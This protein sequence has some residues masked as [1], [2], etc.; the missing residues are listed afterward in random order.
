VIATGA[1]HAPLGIPD[2]VCLTTGTGVLK[3]DE[4]PRRGVFV[5]GGYIAFE[6]TLVA[7]RTSAQVHTLHRGARPLERFDADLFGQL[8]H[9]TRDRG[10][11]V[12]VNATVEAIEQRGEKLV[13]HARSGDEMRAVAADLVVH[14]AG[15][16]PALDDLDLAA[17]GIACVEKDGVAVNAYPQSV[18]PASWPPAATESTTMRLLLRAPGEGD[19]C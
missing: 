4:L 12:Q 2:Q 19:A 15:R 16:V 9:A 14:A 10:V 18:S 6:F 7:A 5:G 8:V 3:L 1:R 17:A 13:V 11:D